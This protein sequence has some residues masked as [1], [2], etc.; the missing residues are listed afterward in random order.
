MTRKAVDWRRRHGRAGFTRL[1]LAAAAVGFL[2][3]ACG[4]AT[5]ARVANQA[6][7][8]EPCME[9]E[10]RGS[11]EPGDVFEQ[12]GR[13]VQ[14]HPKAVIGDGYLDGCTFVVVFSADADRDQLEPEARQAVYGR[15]RLRFESC[16]RTPEQLDK[17]K[18]EV[19]ATLRVA[20][21]VGIHSKSCSA[22]VMS[23]DISD[24]QVDALRQRH[25]DAVTFDRS[26]TPRNLSGASHKP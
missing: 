7:T 8:S 21:G 5:V 23:G 10:D 3:A 4:D 2:L 18:G 11:G 9:P 26:K 25:G 22:Q 24:D 13:F 12:I 17:V 20:A 19:L 16:G 6:G 15:H 1:G 14:R